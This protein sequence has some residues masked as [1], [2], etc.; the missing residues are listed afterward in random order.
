VKED[1]KTL[2]MN[3]K[4]GE[5][6]QNVMFLELKTAIESIKKEMLTDRRTVDQLSGNVEVLKTRC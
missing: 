5:M 1:V 4:D 3:I 6:S 2:S